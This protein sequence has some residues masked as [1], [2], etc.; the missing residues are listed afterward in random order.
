MKTVN[1]LLLQKFPHLAWHGIDVLCY[2]QYFITFTSQ[3]F[4][5]KVLPAVMEFLDEFLS[6]TISIDLTCGMQFSSLQL[7]QQGGGC[8]VL[9][10]SQKDIIHP[11]IVQ[12]L[13]QVSLL[14]ETVFTPIKRE[15]VL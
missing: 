1:Q 15:T 14:G 2:S 13:D 11:I 7:F 10:I 12:T 9:R 6:T 5:V 8:K 4:G 3:N